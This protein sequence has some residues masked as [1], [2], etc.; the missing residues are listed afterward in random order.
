MFNRYLWKLLS[1]K[2]ILFLFS[3]ALNTIFNYS[4]ICFFIYVGCNAIVA[5]FLAGL[6]SVVFNYFSYAK[7]VFRDRN[8]SYLK[9][10]LNHLLNYL[11]SLI[12]L[13]ILG[14]WIA[15]PYISTALAMILTIIMNYV[16]LSRWVFK[17]T[18]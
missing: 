18:A 15:N 12:F 14:V 9:F 13:M 11:C 6:I 5:Q 2:K 16:I 4:G 17:S 1:Q 3:G 8:G 10:L 7:I